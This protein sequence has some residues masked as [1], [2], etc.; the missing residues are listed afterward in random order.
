[1]AGGSPRF[2]WALVVA[3]LGSGLAGGPVAAGADPSDPPPPPVITGNVGVWS[4]VDNPEYNGVRCVYGGDEVSQHIVSLH[5]RR[6][7][8]YAIDK[9]PGQDRRKLGWRFYVQG[10]SGGVWVPVAKSNLQK[11]FATDT[12]SADFSPRTYTFSSLDYQFYRVKVRL[13]WYQLNG[14]KDGSVDVVVDWYRN[15]TPFSDYSLED[16][17]FYLFT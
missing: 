12:S 10:Y 2:S 4:L 7:V 8:A 6:P 16:P 13:L 11:A 1:M 15:D 5:I 9:T 3:L 14:Q 17:C